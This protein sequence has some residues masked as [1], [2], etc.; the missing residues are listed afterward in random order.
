MGAEMCVADCQE[1]WEGGGMTEG[2]VWRTTAMIEAGG[3]LSL[4]LQDCC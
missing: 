4:G 1:S 3:W 2:Q